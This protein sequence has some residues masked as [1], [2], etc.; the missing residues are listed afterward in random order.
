MEQHLDASFLRPGPIT[1]AVALG[2]AASGIGF[3]V[4]LAAWGIALIWRPN[5]E[6]VTVKIANPEVHITQK[7]PLVVGQQTPFAIEQPKPVKVE[8]TMPQT[9]V[10]QTDPEIPTIAN[11]PSEPVNVIKREV[12][13]FSTVDHSVGSVTTGWNYPDGGGRIPHAQFCYYSSPNLDRSSTR[14]DLARDRNP[15]SGPQLALVPEVEQALK[16]CQW[17]RS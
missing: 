9:G 6:P 17:W 5:L 12:T 16:K 8:V 14:V 13:V 7:E 2:I 1:K 10:Q 15:S 4:L 3:G 11:S